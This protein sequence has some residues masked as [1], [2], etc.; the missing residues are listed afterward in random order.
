[1]FQ[2]D[3][4]TISFGQKNISDFLSALSRVRVPELGCPIGIAY[5]STN[6]GHKF[7]KSKIFNFFSE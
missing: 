7:S 5:E 1:M 4:I 6:R 2:D 3:E